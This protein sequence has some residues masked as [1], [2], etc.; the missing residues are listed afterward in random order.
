[1]PNG[2]DTNVAALVGKKAI[3]IKEITPFSFGRV[4]V[5]GEDW[6]AISE[7]NVI[8]EEGKVVVVTGWEGV[9][10]IVKEE[11]GDGAVR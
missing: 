1:M 2:S 8:I 6:A 9:K 4:K 5:G 7:N 11:P 3:V 10:L